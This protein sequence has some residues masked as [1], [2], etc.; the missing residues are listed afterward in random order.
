ME[1]LR[2]RYFDSALGRERVAVPDF[3]LPEQDLIIEVKSSFT[4]DRRNM[5]DQAEAYAEAGY[6]VVL[7]YERESYAMDRAEAEL[8][9]APRV[10]KGCEALT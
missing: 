2:I 8:F 5:L 9:D 1:G 10:I 6:G 3:R 4:Y 7:E